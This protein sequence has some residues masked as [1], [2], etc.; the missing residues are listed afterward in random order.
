[1]SAAAEPRAD[2]RS[3]VRQVLRGL[4]SFAIVAGIF[5]GVLPRFASY[6]DVWAT[7][8]DMTYLEIGSLLFVAIWNVVTYWFVMVAALPG[9]SYPQAAVVNQ[10]STAIS[11]TIPGGGALGVGVTYAMYTSWGFDKGPIALSVL[12]SGIWNTFVKL[13]MPVVAL[14]LL[15]IHGGVRGA[16]LIASLAG[17]GLLAAAVV[18]FWLILRSEALARTIG[19][20]LGRAVSWLRRLVRK[21]PVTD[22]AEAASRFRRDTVG[23]L[24]NRWVSL[25]TATVISHTSLYLVL[26]VALRHVGVSDEELSWVT[27]L[28]AF[29]FVRLISAL[30]ITPG[31]VGV[32]ELGYAAALSVGLDDPTTAQVVA[33]MLVFRFLT[34]FIPIPVGALSYVYW[35]RNRSWRREVHP[36]PNEETV[37]DR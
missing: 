33:A 22:W 4:V 6:S 30:P 12:V 25:T 2:R 28:A 23:L 17:V 8:S 24:H 29:A 13:G 5:V 27:V 14:A 11:N 37:G 19:A 34:Y 35:R 32:V 18:V 10:A 3:T 36:V 26:L 15:V 7:I 31:G 1:M 20:R 9:L 21:P 16:L